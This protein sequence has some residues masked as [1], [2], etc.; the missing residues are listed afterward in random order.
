MGCI[1]GEMLLGVP[2]F[3]GT[4]SMHQLDLISQLVGP[5]SPQDIAAL[6]APYASATFSQIST[7]RKKSPQQ[8]FPKADPLAL[9][10]L[11]KLLRYDPSERL[12]TAEAL[13]HPFLA[14]FMADATP[15]SMDM[16]VSQQRESEGD[17]E[18]GGEK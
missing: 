2:I 6:N 18:G 8:M 7:K 10:L 16:E 4:S 3:Q 1:L 15:M 5:P 12:T 13:Q 17:G 14:P 9:D 11:M